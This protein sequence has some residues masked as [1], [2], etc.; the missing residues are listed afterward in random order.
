ME[1][2]IRERL[3]EADTLV[4]KYFPWIL[5]EGIF[6]LPRCFIYKALYII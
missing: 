4:F 5:S 2:T 3:E 1:I 6:T